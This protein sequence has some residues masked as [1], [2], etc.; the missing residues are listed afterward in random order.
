MAP[1]RRRSY[2]DEE[3]RSALTALILAGGNSEKVGPQIGIT[4][5]LLRKW[6]TADPGLY[7]EL[8]TELAPQ[9]AERI[10]SDAEEFAR[11]L[12][13]VERALAAKVLEGLDDLKPSEA[14]GALRNISTSKALQVDKLSSPLRGRPTVIHGHD[15]AGQALIELGRR[16]GFAVDSTAVEIPNTPALNQGDELSA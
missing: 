2:S 5:D 8:R 3:K 12:M 10:A 4:P 6:R 13:N 14:A 11:D 7:E 1:K 9:V 15:D 16:L